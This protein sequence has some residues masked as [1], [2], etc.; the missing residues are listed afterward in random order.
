MRKITRDSGCCK[1]Y[2]REENTIEKSQST[3]NNNSHLITPFHLQP[4]ILNT[5]PNA[6]GDKQNEYPNEYPY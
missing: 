1:E 6:Q 3:V 2:T 5:S 4:V